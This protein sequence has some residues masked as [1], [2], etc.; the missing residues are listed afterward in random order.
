ME[1]TILDEVPRQ[2][3]ALPDGAQLEIHV[4]DPTGAAAIR[5][6]IEDNEWFD[7][8]VIYTPKAP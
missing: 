3:R 8:A 7:V 2:L 5:N 1:R 4:S 6:L